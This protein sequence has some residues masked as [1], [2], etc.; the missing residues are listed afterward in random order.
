MA[1]LSPAPS[2]PPLSLSSPLL[3]VGAVS[4]NWIS[5]ALLFSLVLVLLCKYIYMRYSALCVFCFVRQIKFIGPK[6]R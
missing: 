5:F 3:C 6:I 1:S 2:P 4:A